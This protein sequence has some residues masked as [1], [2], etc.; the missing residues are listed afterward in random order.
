[1]KTLTESQVTALQAFLDAF[2]QTTTGVW[3]GIEK[4]MRENWGIE[5]PE[6]ALEDAH[7][8]LET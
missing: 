4:H 3:T 6:A 7:Q 2:E 1:M 8:A 5:D